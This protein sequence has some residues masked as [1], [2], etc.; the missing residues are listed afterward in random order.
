MDYNTW[1]NLNQSRI[2][3]VLKTIQECSFRGSSDGILNLAE[4]T[5]IINGLVKENLLLTVK[6]SELE[7]ELKSEKEKTSE[8]LKNMRE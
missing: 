2:L 6:I 4:V 7:K 1:Y 8:I 3:K 5:H